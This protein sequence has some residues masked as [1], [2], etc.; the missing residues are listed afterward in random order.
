MCTGKEKGD[1]CDGTVED[2]KLRET[3]IG[4]CIEV[5]KTNKR[6][7]PLEYQQVLHKAYSPSY[8]GLLRIF[9]E[10]SQCGEFGIRADS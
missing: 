3:T 8:K 10:S 6:S 7:D 2:V 1:L 4:T 9:R 5:R